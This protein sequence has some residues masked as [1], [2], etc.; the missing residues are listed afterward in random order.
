MA[1]CVMHN[2][3]EP[4]EIQLRVLPYS[5]QCTL[6]L[7]VISQLEKKCPTLAILREKCL[8]S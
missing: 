5:K 3:E 8:M 2:A 4:R 7:I 1:V 6:R